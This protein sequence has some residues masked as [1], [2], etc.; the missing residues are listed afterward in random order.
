MRAGM[1]KSNPFS[2][3]TENK[4]PLILDGAI[5]SQLQ[6]AGVPV[7]NKTWTTLANTDYPEKVLKIHMDYIQ[8]GAD[9]IT[10][11]TFRTN[12]TALSEFSEN[13]QKELLTAALS[14]AHQAK[15]GLK[16]YI[17]ASNASAED[18]YQKDRRISQKELKYNHHK[19][20]SLLMDNGPDF[21]L[22]ETQSHFDE[23][24]IICE[25]CSKNNVPYVVS[26][27]L[28]ENL[29]LLSG[30]SP[31]DVIPFIRDY[32]P[33]AMGFNCISPA[34]FNAAEKNFGYNWGYYLNCGSGNPEDSVIT[35]G[36]SP[37]DYLSLV[38]DTMKYA[39]SFIGACCGS[40]PEHII[41]IKEYLDGKN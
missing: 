41:K 17:A 33:L 40:G 25:Y 39:P 30:E 26:I 28:D 15:E 13:K 18:C 29:K 5:G 10:T 20:I 4:R 16:V 8:A 3:A 1:N 37:E 24:K 35:C 21:I 2:A 32:E 27:Y 6:Q 38:K 23:I 14:L 12:P 9:I 22:N 11:N 7:H 34:Q 36:F 31:A 19:H